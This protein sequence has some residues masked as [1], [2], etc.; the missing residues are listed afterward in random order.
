MGLFE[1]DEA[2]RRAVLAKHGLDVIDAIEVFG[3]PHL[4]IAARSETEERHLA[5]GMVRH[6]VEKGGTAH[7]TTVMDM[8]G[9]IKDTY[10]KDAHETEA[11]VIGLLSTVD[12]LAIDEVGKSLDTNYEQA[13]F[14]RL[15]D[16]RYRNLKPTLLVTNLN[17]DKLVAYLGD[18][19][20]DRMREA[21]GLLLSFDW[22]TN[23][24]TKRPPSK[25]D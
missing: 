18:A 1:R 10:H 20:V 16:I 2:K 19:V 22:G 6:V 24:S 9:R 13:Q 23:R 25:D 3:A 17:K 21:G 15:M 11:Q 5:I 7:Y 4:L 14:F 12:F 8:L